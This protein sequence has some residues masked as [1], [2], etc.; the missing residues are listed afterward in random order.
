MYF[1]DHPPPHVHARYS[2]EVAKVAIADGEIIVG[3]LPRRALRLVREWI[4]LHRAELEANWDR[5]VDLQP[6][7]PIEPLK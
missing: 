1:G 5:T 3:E 6:P 4:E 7:K 2:G